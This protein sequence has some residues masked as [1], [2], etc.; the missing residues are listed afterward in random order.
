LFDG[1]QTL[2]INANE[3]KQIIDAVQLAKSNGIKK[4]GNCWWIPAYIAEL[5]QKKKTI[6]RTF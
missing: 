2:F 6:Y 4:N 1:S 5:L 3:E